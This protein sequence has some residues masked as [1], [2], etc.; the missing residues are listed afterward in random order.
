MYTKR[1]NGDYKYCLNISQ[2]TTDH[3]IY[4]VAFRACRCP[5]RC[6]VL[7][8]WSPFEKDPDSRR[9]FEVRVDNR[10]WLRFWGESLL[11]AWRYRLQRNRGVSDGRRSGSNRAE[12]L[13]SRT[14]NCDGRNWRVQRSG[15]RWECFENPSRRERSANV[16]NLSLP[17]VLNFLFMVCMGVMLRVMRELVFS[18]VYDTVSSVLFC[19]LLKEIFF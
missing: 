6:P 12:M 13:R 1:N 2:F 15:C 14:S 18:L 5:A 9:S 11:Q 3:G 10:M 7:H 17:P 19:N 8:F 4:G 16:A